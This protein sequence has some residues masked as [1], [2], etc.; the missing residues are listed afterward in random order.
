MEKEKPL[1]LI[2]DDEETMRDSCG[3][4]L[5]KMGLRTET[6]ENG[7]EG[8]EK[9]S[10]FKPD[11]TLIDLKMPGISGFEV[12]GQIKNIDP[13][14][15]SIVIT[16]Y[17]TVESAVEA[18]RE[19]AYDFLP[20]PFTPE[21]LRIIIKRG[22]ERR[23]LILETK[24][25][26]QEK[27]LMEENFIT[28]VSH[29]LR[30]PLV[31]IVQYFEVILGG[32]IQKEEQKTDMLLKARS[33]MERLL[34]LIN[35][36]LDIAR[37]NKGQLVDKLKPL[38]LTKVLTKLVDFSEPVAIEKNI[39]LEISPPSGSDVALGDKDTLEQVFSNLISNALNYTNSGGAVHIAV[40]ED[41][42]SIFVKFSDTGVGIPKE[43]LP[44][45]FNQFYQ[46]K[47]S[48]NRNRESSGLGLFIAQKIVDAHGG[49]ITVSS[50]VGIGSTFTIHLPKGETRKPS[51]RQ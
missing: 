6:A 28:M 26:R 51:S 2:I 41:M 47:K 45:I 34:N 25:L 23:R 13:D 3:L 7:T 22:L 27:K 29:Q 38:S 48:K 5:K 50:E 19:G 31:T 8:I 21:E 46:V 1:I 4:I 43:H 30:S 17:A 10:A 42:D 15:I 9:V 39:T 12:L 33:K 18:M 44:F 20:K 37:M 35:D 40:E 32:F 16:G 36:W 49:K 14:I 24:T 11:I